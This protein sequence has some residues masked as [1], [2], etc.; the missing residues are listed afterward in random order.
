MPQVA[1]NMP[2][3]APA[4][5]RVVAG[6]DV[7]AAVF[8]PHDHGDRVRLD[9]QVLGQPACLVG[10][11]FRSRLIRV[12]DGDQIS[13]DIPFPHPVQFLPLRRVPAC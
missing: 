12:S 4:P 9:D 10:G 3:V 1:Q 11:G 7:V 6:V 2:Q 8:V 13:H 5:T